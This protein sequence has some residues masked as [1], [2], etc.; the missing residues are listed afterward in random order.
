MVQKLSNKI[1]DMEKEKEDRKQFMPYYKRKDESSPSQPPVHSPSVMNLTEV[2][3]DKFCTF[4]QQPHSQ[5]SFP[6]W[7]N[8]MNLVMNQLL[9]S[10]L[11]EHALEE[12][13][14]HGPEKIPEETTTVLWDC[15]AT[16]GLNDEEITKKIPLSVVNVI[17]RSNGPI[18]YESTLLPKI[19]RIQEKMKKFSSNTQTPPI[20]DLVITRQEAPA[21]SKNVNIAGSNI[22]TNKKSSTD[23]D[24]GYDIVEDIKKTKA[25]ISL[26]EMCNL[27]QQRKKLLESFDTQTSKSQYDVQSEEEISE[28]RIVGKYKSQTLPFLLS[29]ENFNHNVQNSLVNS[30]A[31]SNVIPLLVCRKINGQPTP[32]SCKII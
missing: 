10:K 6:Q 9:D 24:M 20:P 31:S 29:F 14:V 18:I 11:T 25:N 15:M 8:S 27:H 19:M 21:V 7:I 26:F 4:H 32:S 17:T 22:E 3:M 5:R 30:G 12:E 23:G 2:G 1:P 28:A 13:K 16:L